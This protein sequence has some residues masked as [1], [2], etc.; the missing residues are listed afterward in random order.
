MIKLKVPIGKSET[1]LFEYHEWEKEWIP[2]QT[3]SDYLKPEL[4]GVQVNR[5]IWNGRSIPDFPYRDLSPCENNEIFDQFILR[6]DDELIIIPGFQ[7]PVAGYLG[8]VG[9][10]GVVVNLLANAAISFLLNT[11]ISYLTAPSKP[12]GQGQS[13]ATSYGWQ[14]IQNSYG[15]GDPKPVIFGKHRVG[16]KV[17]HY[18]V[19]EEYLS[20]KKH[21][22]DL[23]KTK[24][25][26][27]MLGA[28]GRP[29]HH[30]TNIEIN[31]NPI[32]NY[33]SDILWWWANGATPNE[34]LDKDG[35]PI[36][37]GIIPGFDEDKQ[38]IQYGA[39]LYYTPVWIHHNY[40]SVGDLVLATIEN[41]YEY[42]CTVEGKSGGT[43]PTWPTTENGT[44]KDPLPNGPLTWI[45]RKGKRC[46]YTTSEGD[47]RKI[48]AFQVH[49]EAPGGIY[50]S[51]T[52]GIIPNTVT[53]R[54]EYRVYKDTLPYNAWVVLES[55]IAASNKTSVCRWSK[56]ID[57]LTS[58][59][60]DIRITELY[61]KY[62]KTP[63]DS[64]PTNPIQ[65]IIQVAKITE[66]QPSVP[67]RYDGTSLIGIRAL[68]TANV[69]DAPPT[70]TGLCDGIELPVWTGSAWEDQWTDN[71]AYIGRAIAL[72][73]DW[74]FGNWISPAEIN[75]DCVKIFANYCAE[76]NLLRWSE[77]FDNAAWIKINT[78]VTPN[79]TLC[80]DGIRQVADTLTA[81][82]SNGMIVQDI[83]GSS[84][85]RT[86]SVYLKRKT[87]TGTIQITTD[88]TTWVTVLISDAAWT[89]VR[90][91][92]TTINPSLGIKIITSGDAI[93]AW[94][95]MF[96]AGDVDLPYL[97]TQDVAGLP[98]HSCNFVW[99]QRR[100]FMPMLLDVWGGARGTIFRAGGKFYVVPDRSRSPSQLFTMENIVRNSLK[101][102]WVDERLNYNAY[103]V[104]FLS[105]NQGY[106]TFAFSADLGETPIKPKNISLFGITDGDEA[107]RNVNYQLNIIR[108]LHESISFQAGID[109]IYC[110]PGDVINF[111]H[112]LFLPQYGTISGRVSLD[113]VGQ[114]II[115]LDA[116]V[117]LAPDKTYRI[118]VRFSGGNNPDVIETRT[119][120]NGEGVYTDLLVTVNFSQVVKRYDLYVI[121]EV[122]IIVKPYILLEIERKPDQTCQLN[123]LEYKESVYFDSG[124]LEDIHIHLI[125]PTD[126]PPN[127]ILSFDATEE[128]QRQDDLTYVY[129]L[130]LSWSRPVDTL[131]V[132]EYLGANLYY[133]SGEIAAILGDFDT[134]E[135]WVGGVKNTTVGKFKK[136]PSRKVTST[137]ETWVSTIR[138]LGASQDFSGDDYAYIG[139]WV[140][141]DNPQFL[142]SGDCLKIFIKTDDSH[143]YSY[144]KSN[145]T[146][147]GGWNYIL[148][149]KSDLVTH[150]SPSWSNINKYELWIKSNSAQIIGGQ[151][152]GGTVNAS[153]DSFDFF[154]SFAWQF[155]G[156]IDGTSY[157][158]PNAQQG[159]VLLFKVHPYSKT[160][161]ENPTGCAY[162]SIAVTGYDVTAPAMPTGLGL[163]TDGFSITAKWNQNSESDFDGYEIH[164]KKTG[165]EFTP[166]ATTLK[167]GIGRSNIITFPVSSQG[168]YSV[169]LR[170]FDQSD[171]PNYSDYCAKVSIT[172]SI[173]SQVIDVALYN[174]GTY[175]D[176]QTGTAMAKISVEWAENNDSE[177]V[178]DYEILIQEKETDI[179]LP[180]NIVTDNPGFGHGPAGDIP[181]G[182]GTA[183]KFGWSKKGGG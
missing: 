75:D 142:F 133:A 40:Y 73:P 58:N 121:G 153:F 171:P 71:P 60:Y 116:P 126:V 20:G 2:L 48:T 12:K 177:N 11:L 72:D 79:S 107:T 176:S 19:E 93:Y 154:K 168:T 143:Y 117:T 103:D 4:D 68:A 141:I 130:L 164:A 90:D 82:A 108:D 139:L 87:G 86:G 152:V 128:A 179:D 43:E 3:I 144:I 118:M 77:E 14:G 174:V 124:F 147:T 33:G 44:V 46:I 123:C 45:C 149:S 85:Q 99:D 182:H 35:N 106:K 155:K 9:F 115:H 61:L 18:S 54:I 100:K 140:F 151:S 110:L 97:R 96:N 52:G 23:T 10:W 8:I 98:R 172:I 119:I 78:T 88:G 104:S 51:D 138:T 62:P 21:Q 83:N 55:D 34:V 32:T 74:G 178:T 5:V 165:E 15:P 39:E 132:G 167:R 38:S 156:R 101:M 109:A 64:A 92:R 22:I 175:I 69:S 29:I 80:P 157:R 24:M 148:L 122:G 135:G 180:D 31:N 166:D 102:E 112:K 59:R 111:Q 173:P 66:I 7:I 158:W 170:S 6:D 94:G 42:E 161:I 17:I 30:L 70:V 131:G 49:F 27:N 134:A 63:R 37:D 47:D 113:S 65:T 137:A 183:M 114:N 57:D 76:C 105:A 150:G 120:A 53:T 145:A 95:A 169:K 28:I 181:A 89:R 25:W 56:R 1:G 84:V 81:T 146:L 129:N 136:S 50:W 127:P 125:N 159:E 16:V 13:S 91:I 41:E 67:H 160:L 36:A 163:E 26:V 162:A